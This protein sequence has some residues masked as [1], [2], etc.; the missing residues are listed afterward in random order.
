MTSDTSRPAPHVLVV[1][2]DVDTREMYALAL[3]RAGCRVSIA[4]PSP[5]PSSK[6]A[7]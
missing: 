3:V 6:R 7:S 1:D 5:M 2:H 4:A